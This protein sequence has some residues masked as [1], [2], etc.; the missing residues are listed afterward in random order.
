MSFTS[1]FNTISPIDINDPI[2]YKDL[3]GTPVQKA[4]KRSIQ[5]K[6]QTNQLFSEC[7]LTISN[8][9]CGNFKCKYCIN[10][11]L[12]TI[13]PDYLINYILNYSNLMPGNTKFIG[14]IDALIYESKICSKVSFLEREHFKSIIIKIFDDN[15]TNKQ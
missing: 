11:G 10:K 7:A 13:I 6:P 14:T 2:F 15:E 4:V 12:P 9:S 3:Q 5:A 8:I 1:E